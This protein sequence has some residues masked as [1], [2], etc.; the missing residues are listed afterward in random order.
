MG[1][2]MQKHFPNIIESIDVN[3]CITSKE[4]Q[5]IY[6]HFVLQINC[7]A[8]WFKSLITLICLKYQFIRKHSNWAIFTQNISG[9]LIKKLPT[10]QTN[11]IKTYIIEYNI[12][13]WHY[14]KWKSHLVKLHNASV[15]GTYVLYLI[16]R[17][18]FAMFT[19]HVTTENS[20]SWT[21]Y[22][23]ARLPEYQLRTKQKVYDIL[24]YR[25]NDEITW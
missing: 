8:N 4:I 7:F 20:I 3:T 6:T 14:K 17:P 1:F 10:V 5:Y 19:R 18:L 13:V 24:Q 9:V 23:L 11:L 2:L 25:D 22:A 12:L 21:L 15:F 16:L